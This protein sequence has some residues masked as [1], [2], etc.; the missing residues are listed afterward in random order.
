MV[1]VVGA[2]ERATELKKTD[3]A[4]VFGLAV[5]GSVVASAAR[6]LARTWVRWSGRQSF[7][8]TCEALHMHCGVYSSHLTLPRSRTT[9]RI[10]LHMQ[11]CVYACHPTCGRN[12]GP[13][14]DRVRQRL[15]KTAA[16]RTKEG[17]TERSYAV[18]LKRSF[19]RSAVGPVLEP[20]VG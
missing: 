12:T 9:R 13:P 17:G 4:T 18:L 20:H 6:S 19:T 7:R 10:A 14:A 11:W 8:G 5:P 1:L 16:E 2:L 15:S 3:P